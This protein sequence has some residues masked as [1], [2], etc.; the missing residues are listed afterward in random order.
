MENSHRNSGKTRGNT[1]L[2]KKKVAST[3]LGRKGKVIRL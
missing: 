1:E 2:E 3:A